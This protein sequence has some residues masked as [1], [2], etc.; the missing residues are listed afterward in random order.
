M[1]AETELVKELET[2]TK[3]VKKLQ[4]TELL[5]VYKKPGKFLFFSFMKGI[6]VGLGSVLGATVVVALLIYL[7]SQISFVPIV[8]EFVGDIVDQL[9]VH[10]EAEVQ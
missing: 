4:N 10:Q 7:L 1:K 8:G 6:M 9:E 5:R 3:Q 2:L